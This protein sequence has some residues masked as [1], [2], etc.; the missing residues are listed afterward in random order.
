MSIFITYKYNE[1]I[2]IYL[3]IFFLFNTFPLVFRGVDSYL[4]QFTSSHGQNVVDSRGAA[5]DYYTIVKF[6]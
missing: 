1:L 3:Y 6:L 4:P 2:S 5:K